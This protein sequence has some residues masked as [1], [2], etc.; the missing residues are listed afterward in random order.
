MSQFP[1]A[2]R[3]DVAPPVSPL[4]GKASEQRVP[5]REL[6]VQHML[7]LHPPAAVA[8]PRS[9][10]SSLPEPSSPVPEVPDELVWL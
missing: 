1:F 6:T 3:T 8:V 7:L 5:R 2:H 9:P 4:D 10:C